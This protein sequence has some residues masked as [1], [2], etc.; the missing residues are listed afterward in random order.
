MEVDIRHSPSF[1]VARVKLGPNEAVQAQPGSMMAMSFGVEIK[2]KVEGGIFK[3]LGRMMAGESLHITTFTAP[4]NGG[5][6]DI[7]PESQGDV[8]CIDVERSNPL[9]IN[10]GSWLANEIGVE[11]KADASISSYFGG[12]G[13]VILKSSGS[14]QILGNSYGGIDLHNLQ[15]GEGF[16][17][18]TGHLVAWESSLKTR[19]RKAGG[20]ISSM[21]SK[22][23]KVIDITGPGSLITQS[24]LPVVASPTNEN[25]GFSMAG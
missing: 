9:L 14:G 22:E 15:A 20:F 8:F 17:V 4:S 24:R 25:G 7:A 18:D 21:T 3:G 11:V 2:A 1:A 6:V 5:W 19:V 16:T 13:F 23:G 12:E 10:A